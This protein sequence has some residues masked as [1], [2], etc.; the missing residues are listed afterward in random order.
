MNKVHGATKYLV[1]K[2]KD[3]KS[4]GK[5]ESGVFCNLARLENGV[6]IS[7]RKK[8]KIVARQKGLEK[9]W[10]AK[11]KEILNDNAMVAMTIKMD[12]SSEESNESEH[13]S[14]EEQ[15]NLWS[16]SQIK[17]VLTGCGHT[18]CNLCLFIMLQM[19]NAVSSL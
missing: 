3:C 4:K 13:L 6:S 7:K 8:Q 14:N 15:R 11:L 17:R 2:K 10:A 16:G 5:I 9:L 19:N 12:D 1:C 18:A